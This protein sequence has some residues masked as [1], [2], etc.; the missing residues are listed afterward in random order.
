[1]ERKKVLLVYPEIPET[2][3][4]MKHAMS[5]IGK[6]GL[7]P[8]LGLLTVAGYF[9]RDE[10]DL[11]LVDMNTGRLRDKDIAWADLV[12]VSA[13]L[14]QKAS[15]LKVTGLCRRLGVP[16]VAGGP[17]PSS[18]PGEMEGIDYLVLDEGEVTLPRFLEDWREGRAAR[19]YSDQTKPELDLGPLP[20][21]DLVDP[22]DYSSMP[23]Q[24]SR[25][26]PFNCEFCDIVALFGRVPR[27]K[28]PGRF[29]SELEA[30][31]DLGVRGN[32]FVVD[33]NFIGN[34]RNVKELLRALVPWQRDR[35]YPFYLS[36][37]AS[38]DLARDEELLDLLVAANFKMVFVGLETPQELSLKE[39]GKSQNLILEPERA[40]EIIQRKGIEVS[41]GFIVGFDA[42]PPDI[43]DRQVRF[44]KRLAIPMAMVGLLTALPRTELR[45]RLER[46][47]RLVEESNGDNTHS[48]SFNFRTTVPEER[49]L[50]GYFHALAELYRPRAYFDR[51]LE[52]LRRYPV[53][54]RRPKPGEVGAIT[55]INILYLVRSLIVQGFSRYGAEYIRYLV[56]ALSI[57]PALVVDFITL[58][59]Q[60]R[61]FFIITRRFLRL[62]SDA[63]TAARLERQGLFGLRTPPL[64]A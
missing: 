13:M 33:D 57:S 5:L 54:K 32:I 10:F 44:V 18:C 41:G 34:K 64:P 49:L 51:C 28:S 45:R 59:V 23:L 30:L 56:K 35:G 17:Y 12:L 7:M 21:F 16:V 19:I 22:R 37:E 3:W 48:A 36:T 15:F 40:V 9:P 20:R 1:M 39:T 2:Y 4:S 47:G 60:G 38:L 8:P 25:G 26:C 46:E 31:M 11:K 63:L 53:L 61:H 62:R 42:D 52:L 29:I 6:K 43:C 27:T 14:V 58:A 50:D 55:P 24:Y